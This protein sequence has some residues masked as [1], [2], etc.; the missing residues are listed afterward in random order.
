[1]W[2]FVLF[3]GFVCFVVCLFVASLKLQKVKHKTEDSL[4]PPPPGPARSGAA[5]YDRGF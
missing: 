1:M 3:S 5:L 4:P 2:S